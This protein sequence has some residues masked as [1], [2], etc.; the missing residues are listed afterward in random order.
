MAI[1][2]GRLVDIQTIPST[3]G[4][5]YTNASST[6]SFIKGLTL[7]NSNTTAETVKL[8]RVPDSTGSLGTAAVTNQFLEI[9]LAALE[10][11]IFEFPGDGAVLEDTNDSIQGVTTTASKVT[12]QIHGVKDA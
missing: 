4:A 11:F 1:T 3:V 2:R 7:F 10:T 5:L 6:K 8:Y 9:S 12:V